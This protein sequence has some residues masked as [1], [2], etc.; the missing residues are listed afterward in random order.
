MLRSNRNSRK[1]D[2]VFSSHR[3]ISKLDVLGILGAKEGLRVVMITLPLPA[4]GQ[5]GINI[6]A[7]ST[8]S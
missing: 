6:L 2:P 5:Y 3:V 7:A 1:S 8:L 4:C